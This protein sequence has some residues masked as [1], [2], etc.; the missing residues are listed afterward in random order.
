MVDAKKASERSIDYLQS[1][2]PEA[3]NIMMEELEQSDDKT[4][5]E[6]T[7]SFEVTPTI[8]SELL[9]VKKTV[10]YKIFSVEKKSGEVI[11]MKIRNMGNELK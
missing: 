7:L 5:W 6:V 10:L 4:C 9:S 11:S 3:L 2:F 8:P 1:F